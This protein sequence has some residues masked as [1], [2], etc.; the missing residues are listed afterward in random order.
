MCPKLI[1][2]NL[3]MFKIKMGFVV[4]L[5]HFKGLYNPRYSDYI[6]LIKIAA[7]NVQTV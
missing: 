2:S 4:G 1:S 5:Y 6:T 7:T 3:E